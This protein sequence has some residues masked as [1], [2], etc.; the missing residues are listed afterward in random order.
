MVK[1]NRKT[2]QL[3]YTRLKEQTEKLMESNVI[4]KV[5]CGNCEKSYIGQ[6]YMPFVFPFSSE[7]DSESSFFLD[8]GL[9]F[10][11]TLGCKINLLSYTDQQVWVP[12]AL[13]NVGKFLYDIIL[14]DLG[15]DV[16]C[17]NN[18]SK[19]K[20]LYQCFFTVFRHEG[21]IVKEELKPHPNLSKLYRFLRHYISSPRI[22]DEVPSS[23]M[24]VHWY[25]WI[26]FSSF[27]SH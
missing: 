9:A 14:L 21:R 18:R 12:P 25:R 15:F 10:W 8:E 24:D 6:T 17:L 20:N 7:S 16:Y 26:S 13:Q 27:R 11:E 4:H 5:K 19:Q 1:K 22:T 3:L 23:A 2:D